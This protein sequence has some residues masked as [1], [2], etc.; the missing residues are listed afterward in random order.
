MNDNRKLFK[1]KEHLL[2]E[3][4]VKKLIEYCKA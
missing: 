1:D 3:P 2:D 4:E